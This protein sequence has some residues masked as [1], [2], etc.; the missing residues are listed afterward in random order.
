MNPNGK[1]VIVTGAS[2]GIGAAAAQA[3]AAAGA[4][5]VLAARSADKLQA[6]AAQIP[7]ETLVV[8]TDVSDAAA[9]QNLVERTVERFGGIDIVLNNAGVGL[10][11][12][13]ADISVED[14]QRAFAVDVYGPILLTQAA[15][16]YLR[17]RERG[18]L[19][20]VSSVVGW[21]SLPFLGG[22]AAAK[23]ALDR[24]VEAL[25]TELRGSSIAVTLVR[26]GT[27]D[28]A[29]T[30]SRLGQGSERRQMKTAAATP[31]QVARTIVRAAEREPREAYVTFGDFA[32]VWLALLFPG[33]TD[34][35]LAGSFT[36]DEKR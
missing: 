27:T 28:T 8:P 19:I 14:L 32:R 21:R 36:W 5:V 23:S 12:P 4:K 26:P 29:F 11:A 13:V 35:T 7:G 1:V 31:A 10:A 24:L 30:E 20:Y 18:Q 2:S 16:P 6:L 15:L 34:R 25:R 17:Q 3:F 33:I 22:Y 9:V